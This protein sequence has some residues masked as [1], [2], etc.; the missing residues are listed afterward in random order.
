MAMDRA[1]RVST[2]GILG[3]LIGAAFFERA[4]EAWQNVTDFCGPGMLMQVTVSP[5]SAGKNA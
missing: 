3:S 4:S 1:N 2:L 5:F